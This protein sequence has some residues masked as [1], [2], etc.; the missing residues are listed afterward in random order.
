MRLFCGFLCGV[1]FVFSVC[2][3]ADELPMIGT[4]QH[5][6]PITHPDSSNPDGVKE[7]TVVEYEVPEALREQFY[8]RMH[9]RLEQHEHFFQSTSLLPKKVQLGM[10]NVPVLDQGRHGSCTTF[11]A[12][13]ALDAALG[14]GDYVSQLCL[15]Q[16]GN[17]L[18]QQ[19]QT[20]SGWNGA[21]TGVMLNR[22][23][24]Y[25]VISMASQ[26]RYGCGGYHYYPYFLTPSSG[27]TPE[28]YAKHREFSLHDKVSW[29][30]ITRRG[31]YF[32]PNNIEKIK[33]ALHSGSRV[34][35]SIL[36]PRSDLGSMG[37]TGYYH[38]ANDTWV[39]THEI[40][41]DV[42]HSD[43]VDGHAIIITGYDDQAKAVDHNGRS[44]QGLFTLRNSWGSWVGDWGNFYMSYDY[45]EILIQQMI[46]VNR[47]KPA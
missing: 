46:Q 24:Q 6:I 9:R 47:V 7:I 13:A 25:G 40:E 11:A 41:Q 21:N 18:E 34:L 23:A 37:A 32:G 1:F 35:V 17:Y 12:T 5:E 8:Q 3:S 45:A 42:L 39:L 30:S 15:L 33:A 16:L 44:H 43:K 4:E 36:L 19:S 20:K 28:D 38:Y 10:A 2:A 29:Q 14:Q 31:S 27:M 22:I 26:H